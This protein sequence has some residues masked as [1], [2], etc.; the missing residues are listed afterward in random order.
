MN[1]T[2][3]LILELTLEARARTNL[4][5]ILVDSTTRQTSSDLAKRGR[6]IDL[7][8]SYD[9]VIVTFNQ[10]SIHTRKYALQAP[11]EVWRR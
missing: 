11:L 8:R 2:V 4:E 6:P 1:G 7:S 9:S 3:E 5:V 10:T